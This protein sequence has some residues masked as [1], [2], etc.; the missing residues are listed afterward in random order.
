[1]DVNYAPMFE[2]SGVC[3]GP[4]PTKAKPLSGLCCS[5]EVHPTAA[6]STSPR[7]YSHSDTTLCIALVFLYTKYTGWRQNDFNVYA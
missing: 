4:D 3:V 6:G 2:E 1:M 7:R 5:F